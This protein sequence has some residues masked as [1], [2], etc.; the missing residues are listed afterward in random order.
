MKRTLPDRK[1]DRHGYAAAALLVRYRGPAGADDARG[2][3]IGFNRG[4]CGHAVGFRTTILVCLAA[5]VTMRQTNILLP[6]SG[7]TSESFAV[8]DLM[9]PPLGILDGVGFTGGG[10]ILKGD[11]LV[12]GVAT[13][14]TLWMVTVI[15]LCLGGGRHH[16]TCGLH[17]LDAEVGGCH[18]PART[19]H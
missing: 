9:R 17:T 10:T 16:G 6:L 18:D 15:G 2:A 3:I 4:A 11:D 1:G 8:M 5:S 14:A 7:E 19:P 13:A 12:T